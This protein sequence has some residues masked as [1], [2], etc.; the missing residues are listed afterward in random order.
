MT[1]DYGIV[2]I[3]GLF[4][5][6]IHNNII[7]TEPGDHVG[8]QCTGW[9]ESAAPAHSAS[10][11]A[12]AVAPP[13]VDVVIVGAGWSGLAAAKVI[14]DHNANVSSPADLVTFRL[15]CGGVTIITMF[16]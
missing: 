3:R 15:G 11:I 13:G 5:H 6:E 7:I 12:N 2:K 4:T 14:A 16:G 8:W 1:L 9:G 10:A